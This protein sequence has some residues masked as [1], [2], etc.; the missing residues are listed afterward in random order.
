MPTY[1]LNHV[2]IRTADLEATRDFYSDVIG[3]EVGFRPPFPSPKTP[4]PNQS[5]A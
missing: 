5:L 1:H 2:N 4:V 3:L